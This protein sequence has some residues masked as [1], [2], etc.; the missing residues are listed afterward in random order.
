[1]RLTHLCFA[2]DLLIFSKGNLASMIGIQ[3][4]LEKFYSFSDLKL[5]KE[6]SEVFSTGISDDLLREIKQVTGFKMG[7]LP[8]RYL[9]VPLVTRRLT[10]AD[11]GPLMDKILA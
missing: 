6:K 10:E 1:M 7:V 8:V 4:V 9:G 11:C 3:N 2:D 5:N